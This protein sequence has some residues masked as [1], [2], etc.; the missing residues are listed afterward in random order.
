MGKVY[1]TGTVRFLDIVSP[2]NISK[3][4]AKVSHTFSPCWQRIF[5]GYITKNFGL[6]DTYGMISQHTEEWLSGLRRT[7][8]KRVG[9]KPSQVRILSLPLE[10]SSI[11]LDAYFVIGREETVRGTVS[12]D[13]KRLVRYFEKISTTCTDPV[14]IK[15]LVSSAQS[16]DTVTVD[17]Q[18]NRLLRAGFLRSLLETLIVPLNH[19]CIVA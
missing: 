14:R 8:G 1:L 4:L 18:K 7:L 16:M 19:V 5:P 10:Q 6:S 13:L 3:N 9:R 2:H 12:Q 11:L 17:I 15:T